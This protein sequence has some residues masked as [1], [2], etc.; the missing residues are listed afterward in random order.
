MLVWLPV[1]VLLGLLWFLKNVLQQLFA[2]IKP[3]RILST[4]PLI[5]AQGILT[6]R[7]ADVLLSTTV[8]K[9]QRPIRAL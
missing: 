1:Q 2:V 5:N 6:L 9:L 8:R 3:M 7:T 4:R